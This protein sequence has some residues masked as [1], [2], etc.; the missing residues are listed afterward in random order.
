MSDLKTQILPP[1]AIYAATTAGSRILSHQ[2]CTIMIL[3]FLISFLHVEQPSQIYTPPTGQWRDE[4]YNCTANIWPSCGCVT[5]GAYFGGISN[6][7]PPPDPLPQHAYL[8][9]LLVKFPQELVHSL[10]KL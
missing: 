2:Y 7:C 3:T 9:I 10:P 8:F 5:M 6:I 4:W 1:E